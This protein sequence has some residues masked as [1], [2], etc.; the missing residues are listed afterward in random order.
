MSR[1]YNPVCGGYGAFE[2]KAT[3]QRNML[4][5][6]AVTVLFAAFVVGTMMVVQLL[7]SDP[8][9]ILTPPGH[10]ID[11]D[12]GRTTSNPLPTVIS[13]GPNIAS[14]GRPPKAELGTKPVLIA[15]SL[16]RGERGGELPTDLDRAEY[17]LVYDPDIDGPGE[18]TGGSNYGGGVI[19]EYPG[20]YEF[21]EN[22]QLPKML[23][24]AVPEFPRL[25]KAA[26][27]SGTIWVRVLV[28]EEGHVLDAFVEKSTNEHAG[29]EEAA[30]ETAYDCVFSPGIQNG[31]PVKVWVSFK[32]E[33]DLARSN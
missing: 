2:M 6:L 14:G 28:D 11:D 19:D 13:D 25:A 15:D 29:F 16:I 5:G 30:L 22:V 3:Y 27:M 26:G 24:A 33:F 18:G 8:V 12:S 4:I 10:P 17:G 23:Q 31:N 21:R 32:F 20:R 7:L 1:S 9:V